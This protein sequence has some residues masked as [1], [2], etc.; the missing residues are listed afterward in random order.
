[1][2]KLTVLSSSD[3]LTMCKCNW[4]WW[5]HCVWLYLPL[6]QEYRRYHDMFIWRWCPIHPH[7]MS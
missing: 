2:G 1:M 5:I 4:Y 6:H 7:Q 3:M